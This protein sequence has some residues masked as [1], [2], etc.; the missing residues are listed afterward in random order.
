MFSQRVYK[1]LLQ[2]KKQPLCQ[3]TPNIYPTSIFLSVEISH[4]YINS[5]ILVCPN[6]QTLHLEHRKLTCTL[7]A[8]KPI[9]AHIQISM[10]LWP[11]AKWFTSEGLEAKSLM[12]RNR[13]FS[14]RKATVQRRKEKDR[15]KR[16]QKCSSFNLEVYLA[17][18][19]NNS[20]RQISSNVK[21]KSASTLVPINGYPA[22]QGVGSIQLYFERGKRISS[23]KVVAR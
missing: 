16:K 17:M 21:T 4:D 6:T 23:T 1:I 8:S 3:T 12:G 13:N 18:K 22:G 9:S 5:I 19:I 10:N 14:S 20:W 7:I 11:G 2:N 15:R